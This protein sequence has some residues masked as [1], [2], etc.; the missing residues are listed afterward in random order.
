MYGIWM[1]RI[2]WKLFDKLGRFFGMPEA[3]YNHQFMLGE[4]PPFLK[5]LLTPIRSGFISP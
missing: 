4:I 2:L 3:R 5:I 1:P